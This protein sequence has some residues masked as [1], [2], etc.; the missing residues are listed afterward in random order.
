MQVNE[1]LSILQNRL[2]ALTESRV[3]AVNS[4]NLELVIT[5]DTNIAQTQLTIS[6]LEAVQ[7]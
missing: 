7:Q 3:Q 2:I 1:I 4:G 5:L 6:Q